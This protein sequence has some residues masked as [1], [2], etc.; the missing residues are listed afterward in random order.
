MRPA[1][2]KARPACPTCGFIQFM[3]PKVGVGVMVVEEGQ[4]LL[5]QRAMRPAIGQWTVPA[6]YLDYGE[7]PRQVAARETFEETGL[8][9][10]VGELVDVYHNPEAAAQGGASLFVLYRAR[11][12]GGVLQAGDDAA[13]AAF[14]ALD[15]LP[16]LAFASTYDV[17]RRLGGQGLPVEGD[18]R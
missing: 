9:V 7:D 10:E 14:F 15:H 1:G 12:V 3:E 2:G 4:I 16:P 11:V 13:A 5:V 8:V 17:I 6:G 18:G